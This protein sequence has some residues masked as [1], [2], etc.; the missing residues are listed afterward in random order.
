MVTLLLSPEISVLVSL[1]ATRAAILA[2]AV[3]SGPGWLPSLGRV[4]QPVARL[5]MSQRKKPDSRMKRV[6]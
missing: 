4:L 1:V 5:M 3:A 2:S 6:Q